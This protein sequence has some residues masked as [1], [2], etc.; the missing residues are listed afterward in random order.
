MQSYNQ[1]T[2]AVLCR[3]DSEITCLTS[4]MARSPPLT[5][6][7]WDGSKPH[8]P[9][10][11]VYTPSLWEMTLQCTITHRLGTFTNWSLHLVDVKETWLQYTSNRIAPHF[12]VRNEAM[13]YLYFGWQTEAW[14]IKKSLDIE[15]MPGPALLYLGWPQV[16][17]YTNMSRHG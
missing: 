11:F 8:T 15:Y 16:N 17:Q 1:L 3:M 13:H 6:R 4:H 9:N 14:Q 5:P 2:W 12:H 7:T 10:Y